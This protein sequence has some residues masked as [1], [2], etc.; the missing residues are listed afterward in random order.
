MKAV[1]VLLPLLVFFAGCRPSVA[2]REARERGLPLMR[3]AQDAE[4]QGDFD[5]AVEFYHE[6]L[7]ANPT[8]ASAHLGLALLLQEHKQDFMAAAYHYQR[9]LELQPGSQKEEMVRYRKKITEQFLTQQLVRKHGDAA[10]VIQ[11]RMIQDIE[12]FKLKIASLESEKTRL[13][14]ENTGHQTTIKTQAAEIERQKR[15]LDNL[16]KAA[17]ASQPNTQPRRTEVPDV[18]NVKAAPR[19][20]A[21]PSLEGTKGTEGTQGTQGKNTASPPPSRATPP[22]TQPR[23]TP[24]SAQ[25]APSR[26]AQPSPPPSSPTSL[27]SPTSPT[28][29]PAPRLHT[30]QAGETLYRISER[31]YNDPLKW[32]LI[33]D[34]NPQTLGVDGRLRAGQV[35]TIPPAGRPGP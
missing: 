11:Q 7:L 3:D 6:S 21:I 30:V 1:F 34:A 35:L 33:R 8:A 25:P 12:T 32:T 2:E 15:L 16:N 22:S 18:S 20:P 27:S 19:P 26:D 29:T 17:P 13:E 23:A 28:P 31:Y 24:P 4:R 9:Y 10:G 14:N 5:K